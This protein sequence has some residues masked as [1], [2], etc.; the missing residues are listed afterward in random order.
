MSTNTTP[1]LYVGHNKMPL[2]ELLPI[3]T[4]VFAPDVEAIAARANT[5][6][7]AIT[8]PADMDMA[9]SLI[10]DGK[11]LF[12]KIETAR[13]EMK[14]PFLD[15]GKLVDGHYGALTE[16]LDRI[17]TTFQKAADAYTA[18]Q[19]ELERQRRF[20]EAERIRKEEEAARAISEAAEDAGK[21]P[22]AEAMGAMADAAGY[23]ARQLEKEAAGSAADLVRTVTSSGVLTSAKTPWVHEITDIGE[24][25]LN[26][27]RPY[28]KQEA[29]DAAIRLAIRQGVRSIRGVRIFQDVKAV[30]R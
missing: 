25:D 28:I 15:G 30:I 10:K 14:Q 24:V 4:A 3:A 2:S 12:K 6:P 11:T 9:A 17:A 26:A 29:I 27:L 19:L 23:E 20:A 13:K 5:A 8:G 1:I 18:Q 7:R 22:M 21:T 16:R